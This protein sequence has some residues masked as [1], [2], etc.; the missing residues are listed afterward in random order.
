M[1]QFHMSGLYTKSSAEDDKEC[2]SG[3]LL[4]DNAGFFSSNKGSIVKY[5]SL[6]WTERPVSGILTLGKETIDLLFIEISLDPN[7][8]DRIHKLRAKIQP[9]ANLPG[10]NIS[11]RQNN[12]EISENAYF[13]NYSGNWSLLRP[14]YF[15][16]DPRIDDKKLIAAL[17]FHS[18]SSHGERGE[19]GIEL[20]KRRG[21]PIAGEHKVHL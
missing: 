7:T 2:L 9:Y 8:L 19:S 6:S 3:R 16:L 5:G 15:K 1:Y 18:L 12:G 21:I 10:Y 13:G 14:K 11:E 4:V 20:S 17:R